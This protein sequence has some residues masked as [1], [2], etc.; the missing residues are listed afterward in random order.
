MEWLGRLSETA[1]LLV[2][3]SLGRAR[4][5]RLLY[6]L[7]KSSLLFALNYARDL[8][9]AMQSRQALFCQTIDALSIPENLGTLDYSLEVVQLP[10]GYNGVTMLHALLEQATIANV[11]AAQSRVVTSG[12]DGL[13]RSRNNI[14]SRW[15]HSL[16]FVRTVARLG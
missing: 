1:W 7:F 2:L 13:T 9:L 6:R 15:A 8:H 16:G 5:V 10:I 12:A 4:R 11:E 3:G 14:S